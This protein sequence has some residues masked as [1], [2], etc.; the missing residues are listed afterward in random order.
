MVCQSLVPSLFPLT[1][2][3]YRQ[4]LRVGFPRAGRYPCYASTMSQSDSHASVP[5]SFP[6]R[7]VGQYPLSGKPHGSPKFM[8]HAFDTIPRPQTPDETHTAHLYAL[9]LVAFQSMNTVGLINNKHFGAQSLHL[10]C[11]LVSPLL[12]LHPF[13]CLHRCTFGNDLLV[14]LWSCRTLTDCL[15]HA[16]LG[17]LIACF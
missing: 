9:R 2:A 13:R 6:F 15:L 16:L 14:R 7:I 4:P 12:W 5:S 3:H 17:A 11:G 8:Q 10:R 1:S